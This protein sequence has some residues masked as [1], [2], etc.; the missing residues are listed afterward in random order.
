LPIASEPWQFEQTLWKACCPFLKGSGTSSV[1]FGAH[2]KA[3]SAQKNK[4]MEGC[5]MSW[6]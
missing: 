4:R 1:G 2:E 6:G 3:K 5:F